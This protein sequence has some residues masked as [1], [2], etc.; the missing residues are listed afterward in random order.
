M[1]LIDKLKSSDTINETIYYKSKIHDHQ[2][3]VIDNTGDTFSKNKE[4]KKENHSSLIDN[5]IQQQ[6]DLM[7]LAKEEIN[8]N[9]LFIKFANSRKEIK[10]L[11]EEKTI[12]NDLNRLRCEMSYRIITPLPERL[13]V[14]T[15]FP[16]ECLQKCGA[17]LVIETAHSLQVSIEAVAPAFIAAIFIASHGNYI[18]EVKNGYQEALTEYIVVAIPSGGR[19][20]AIVDFFRKPINKIET[21]RQISFDKN[22]TSRKSDLE[23]LAAIKKILKS[24]FKAK[25]DVESFDQIKVA[26]KQ[27][28]EKLESIDREIQQ[29][30]ERP[31]LLIDKPTPKELAMEMARQDEAIAIFEAEGSIW[32]LRARP[33]DDDILLKGYTMEPFGDETTTASV[34]MQGPCLTICTYIQEPVAEKLF[35]NDTLKGHGLLARILPVFVHEN[36]GYRDAN[37]RD[38]SDELVKI[39]SDKIHSLF[40][41]QRPAGR[42]GERTFH[43]LELTNEARKLWQN[44]AAY[45]GQKIT[46]GF[47]KDFE[48]FGEKLA[49]HAVRLAGALHLLKYD[50]PHEHKI[51][52]TTMNAGVA[53]AEY[54]ATHATVA[55]DKSHLQGIQYA[56]KILNWVD[57]HRKAQFTEREAHRGVGHCKIEDIRAGMF[58]LEQHGFI[59]RYWTQKRIYCIVNPNYTFNYS[60]FG[61]QVNNR[62]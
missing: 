24:K 14:A 46:D 33:S 56:K 53:L 51:D 3:K 39:Y 62:F 20:S 54:F 52:A 13:A 19:K 32:K 8:H 31:K 12:E 30:K 5:R 40:S 10:K 18:I 1:S 4:I 27:L 38:V 16:L 48:S 57:H 17:G 25:I 58:L 43:T 49:G 55:F 22:A 37:P 29:L 11:Q 23:A 6:S 60:S 45:I 61:F 15:Q 7:T 26:M 41:I 47:F 36:H 50:V 35:S 21:D 28:S 34:N 2:F 44:Y 42:E 59:G 9:Q